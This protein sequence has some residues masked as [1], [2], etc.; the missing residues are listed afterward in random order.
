MLLLARMEA[1]VDMLQPLTKP[2]KASQLIS[3]QKH[4]ELSENQTVW[5]SHSQGFKEAIFK[6]ARWVRG[7]EMASWV[8][9]D[10]VWCRETSAEQE[11]PHSCVVDKSQKGY[12]G[13]EHPSP[14]TKLC[15]PEFQCWEEKA[16]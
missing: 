15:S 5:K 9:E 6:E 10:T 8:G 7:V 4:P 14:K 11:V 1:L 12:L 3:K 13:N 2:E 16:S